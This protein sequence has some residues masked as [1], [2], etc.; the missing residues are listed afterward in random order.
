MFGRNSSL[1]EGTSVHTASILI[2]TS[3][4][5]GKK[6]EICFNEEDFSYEEISTKKRS[7]RKLEVTYEKCMDVGISK[8]FCYEDIFHW[9]SHRSARISVVIEQTVLR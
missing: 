7:R 3:Q 6:E 8:D 2:G 9:K 5:R 4:S 1:N